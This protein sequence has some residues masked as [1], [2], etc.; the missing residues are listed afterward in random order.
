MELEKQLKMK[1]VQIEQMNESIPKELAREIT[2]WAEVLNI[3]GQLHAAAVYEYGLS[4]SNRREA[5]SQAVKTAEG[6]QI[7]KESTAEIAA[8]PYRDKEASAE[9]EVDKWKSAFIST[10]HI[11]NAKKLELKVLMDEWGG[12]NQ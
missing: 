9:S 4:Q 12:K 7:V 10:E 2:L 11:I 8:K 6:T 5:Y 1:Y 3:I